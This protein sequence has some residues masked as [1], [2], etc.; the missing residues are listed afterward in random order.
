M[1][2]D[3]ELLRHFA[4]TRADEAFSEL[5]RRHL[6]G[7]YSA[8]LRR[9]GG[10]THLAEDIAQRV[11]LAL[12]RKAGAVASHPL[13][14]AWLYTTTRHEAANAVRYERR[15]KA[16][17]VRAMSGATDQGESPPA[18]WSRIAPL[19]DEAVDQLGEGDRTAIVLRFVER[20]GFARIGAAL[21]ISEDAA[22]MR[23]ERALEKLR[24][25]LARR[26]ITSTAVALAAVLT[27]QAVT[28]APAGF[29]TKVIA[30]SLAA[31]AVRSAG[32]AAAWAALDFMTKLKIA[33][34][35]AS[36]FAAVGTG[37]Y[38]VAQ[39]TLSTRPPAVTNAGGAGLADLQAENQRL[40][41]EV[42]RLQTAAAD[43]AAS[44]L[45]ELRAL[46]LASQQKVILPLNSLLKLERDQLSPGFVALFNLTADEKAAVE[47]ELIQMRDELGALAAAN[48]ASVERP[49]ATSVVIRCKRFPDEGGKVHDKLVEDLT[50]TLGTE[51]FSALLTLIGDHF[52][53]VV[54]SGFG[55]AEHTYKVEPRT[56]TVGQVGNQRL[57]YIIS[58]TILQPTRAQPSGTIPVV[59]SRTPAPPPP[60]A[61]NTTLAGD[62]ANLARVYPWLAKLL[63]ADF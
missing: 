11:F 21:R 1:Q 42:A 56:M 27:S 46:V 51:R 61:T 36:A 44:P 55:A 58:D 35:A 43:P 2:D 20:Q 33:L 17:E 40:K 34:V 31:A 26:G 24:G 16:R 59:S 29:A 22:R 52:D 15:R 13:L 19:L 8:A 48:V 53:W 62:R 7:V 9:V 39:Q 23:V 3:A 30:S 63:P 4:A 54:G 12:A 60:A 5:V 37:T 38:L 10:D 49:S 41:T 6:D 28:P 14:P 25:R 47:K 57:T 18:D 45:A 50:R 32:L